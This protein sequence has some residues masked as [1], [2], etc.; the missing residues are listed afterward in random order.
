[1]QYSTEKTNCLLLRF[2]FEDDVTLTK[3]LIELSMFIFTYP[4]SCSMYFAIII[5]FA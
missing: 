2:L 5:F 4:I 3:C 1:M